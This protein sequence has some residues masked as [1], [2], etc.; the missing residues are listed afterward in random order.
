MEQSKEISSQHGN[1][2]KQTQ[3][4]TT[5]KVR[6]VVD[7]RAHPLSQGAAS[8]TKLPCKN[9]KQTATCN[10]TWTAKREGGIQP[11]REK[12][13]KEINSQHGNPSKKKK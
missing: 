9:E 8:K 2:S 13:D 6:H 11:A 12:G 10:E 5:T 1:P 3:Q 7:H 4:Q